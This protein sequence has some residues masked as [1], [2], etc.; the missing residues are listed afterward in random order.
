MLTPGT[1]QFDCC[2]KNDLFK[3]ADFF[4]ILVMHLRKM[5]KHYCIKNWCIKTKSEC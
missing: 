2:R 1:E 3:I 4:K 5:F